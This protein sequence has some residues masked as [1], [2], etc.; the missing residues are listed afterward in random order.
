MTAECTAFWH[1]ESSTDR[2][3][4]RWLACPAARPRSRSGGWSRG[5]TYP[6]RMRHPILLSWSGG[7]DGA[8]ALHTLRS[9][10]DFEPVGLLTSI[11]EGYDRISIHGVRRELLERQ[12]EA[13]GLPLRQVLIPK[14]CTNEIYEERL[15]TALR[16]VRAE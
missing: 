14:D 3:A 16:E 13:I 12:A 9:A 6:S 2:A 4:S 5:F 15:A 8:F 7:N 11:T 1:A 10:P